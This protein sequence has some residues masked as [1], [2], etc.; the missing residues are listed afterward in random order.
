ML[1]GEATD[2]LSLSE[3]YRNISTIA[4]IYIIHVGAGV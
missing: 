1:A 3:I 2:D 4:M